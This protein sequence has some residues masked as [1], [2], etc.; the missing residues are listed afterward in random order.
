M[1][2]N[3]SECPVDLTFRFE[4][5]LNKWNADLFTDQAESIDIYIYTSG[6]SFVKAVRASRADG[7]L[8]NDNRVKVNLTQGEYIAIA[9]ANVQS[10]DYDCHYQGPLSEKQVVLATRGGYV[11]NQLT[12]LMHG[13]VKLTAE[14]NIMGQTQPEVVFSMTKNTNQVTVLLNVTGNQVP[15]TINDFTVSAWSSN[16][17]YNY[18]NSFAD[19]DPLQY[20]E[21]CQVPD[22]S[23]Y[24][25]DFHVLRLVPGDDSR[26]LIES[27]H[28]TSG[29]SISFP[30]NV[31]LTEEILRH[32]S[33]NTVEDLD[34]E[35]EF[36]LTYAVDI[37]PA[38]DYGLSLIQINDWIV[39]DQGG[40]V[41]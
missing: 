10:D 12:P 29:N 17:A 38:G 22:N 34:R 7:T 8:G 6:G 27:P 14:M 5:T 26:L 35:D 21:S 16:G 11:N 39:I 32:P 13:S 19:S 1:K 36:T 37:S 25:S 30:Y 9:W 40:P 23:T 28:A 20:I 4:Y 15:L 41:K 2:D 18:D 33:Y 31:S 3:R 24:Q